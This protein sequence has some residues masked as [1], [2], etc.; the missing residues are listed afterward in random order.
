MPRVKLP[1][2]WLLYRTNPYSVIGVLW[3]SGFA[4]VGVAKHRASYCAQQHRCISCQA[5]V[6]RPLSPRFIISGLGSLC[7]RKNFEFFPVTAIYNFRKFSCVFHV[8]APQSP[9]LAPGPLVTH[10]CIAY[11]TASEAPHSPPPPCRLKNP[12]PQRPSLPPRFRC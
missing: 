3:L 2:W 12:T 10:R 4:A 1:H 11:R 9:P 8:T 7:S 6:M 5:R